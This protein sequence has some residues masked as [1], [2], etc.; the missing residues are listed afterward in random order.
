MS[1]ADQI[2]AGDHPSLKDELDRKAGECLERLVRHREQGKIGT[3]A[4]R[5][6]VRSVWETVSG[7]ASEA[8]TDL[9]SYVYKEVGETGQK[10]TRLFREVTEGSFMCAVQWTPGTS[11]VRV[12]KPSGQ[13]EVFTFD[14][15]ADAKARFSL[16]GDRLA[17]RYEEW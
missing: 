7:I 5:I 9:A 4:M 15:E 13:V 14:T 8:T 10:Q 2:P 6:G 16:L 11:V 3:D 1:K 12:L 17:M